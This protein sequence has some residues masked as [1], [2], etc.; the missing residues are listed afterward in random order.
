MPNHISHHIT[1]EY[2]EESETSYKEHE[3]TVL[4][5]KEKMK[6]S[7]SEFDFNALIPM[8]KELNVR[9]PAY[10]AEEKEQAEK[11]IKK[12]SFPD[13]YDWC[14][15]KWGT[16]WNAYGVVWSY[17]EL[18]F[19]TAWNT[20]LPILEALSRE[21]P[22]VTI[23]VEYADEDIGH[24]CGVY[25]LRGGVVNYERN[26]DGLDDAHLFAEKVYEQYHHQFYYAQLEAEE[27]KSRELQKKL[28]AYE[29]GSK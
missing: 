4:A 26:E 14:I 8:P 13:W 21:F 11:N 2:D 27:T 6:T 23:K 10:S 20:P 9:S 24:N 28:D 18:Y 1:F 5:V 29:G 16:K 12:Y 15:S 3:K 17:D 22:D 25:E 7:D 19:Q